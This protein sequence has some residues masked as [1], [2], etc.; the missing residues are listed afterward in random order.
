MM[1]QETW[2]QFLYLL[3]KGFKTAKLARM[4]EIEIL[5][6]QGHICGFSVFLFSSSAFSMK[7]FLHF[8][9]DPEDIHAADVVVN[10]KILIWENR[11]V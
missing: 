11:Y 9:K 2:P 6:A 3:S 1:W 5:M 8:F 10:M 4:P 7:S